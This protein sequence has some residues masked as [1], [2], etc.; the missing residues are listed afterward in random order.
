MWSTLVHLRFPFSWFLLPVYLFSLS[1][2]PNLN[3][4]RLL[5]VFIIL[6]LLVYPASN[7]FNSYFD[8][9]QKSIA[10]IKN[11]PP[12][13][14]SLYV[15]ALMLDLAALILAY[16]NV[17][18]TFTGMVLVYILLSRAYSHPS[19]RLKKYPV[20]SWLIT[21]ITQGFF[22]FLTCYVGLNDFSLE[23]AL[24]PAIL[25]PAL[26]TTLML[27]GNYPLT[28]VYQH[29][30]DEARGDRTISMRLGIKG[31]FYFSAWM[32]VLAGI[33]FIVW[34]GYTYNGQYIREFL[35]AM[36]PVILF[37]TFWFIRVLQNAAHASFGHA[38]GMNVVASTSLNIFFVYLFL[39]TSHI[40]N[41]L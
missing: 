5:W 28:Q 14:F 18:T 37:F 13:N 9:D 1:Y 21:G 30:E 39:S 31:T 4:S 35:L 15:I 6:H 33:G 12:V 36:A 38:M 11:P 2:A 24:R 3:E 10:L 19:V 23:Q 16:A 40:L 32:F 7:G 29:E 22:V 17:N 25:T 20:I 41:V 8:R 26:L 27:W 34:F